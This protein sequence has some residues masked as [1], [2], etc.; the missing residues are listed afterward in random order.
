MNYT[1]HQLHVFL[2]ITQNKS[3][4]KA[5][6]ELHLT[7]P[8]VSI[9][10]KNFQDQFDVP[11]TEVI[12]R[13]LFVTDFGKE[14]AMAAEKILNEVHA[15]NYKTMAFKG[16]LTG[17]LKISV[18]STGKYVIPYFLSDFLKQNQG[19][20]L[21]LDVT[22]KTKVLKNLERNEVDFSLVSVLP[23]TL[24]IEK[25]E[26]MPNSLFLVANSDQKMGKGIQEK[27]IIETLPII[28]REQGSGTRYV[29]EKFIEQ[30]QLT[31]SK[32]MV[33]TGNEAVKQAVLAGLGC[34][35]MPLIGIK[36]ELNNGDLQIIPVKGLPIQSNWNLIW[37]KGKKFSPVAD[38]YLKFIQKEKTRIIEQT[39]NWITL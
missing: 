36:N 3:I 23:E 28:Y 16:Q 22:N 4:T 18:V 9:Q 5:A 6:M 19:V 32:K 34:S 29:M 37:L 26:L 8:A 24:Q 1:L 33:L 7:Q 27:K 20:E 12:G 10:L 30:N 25:V 15:I 31:V 14:I 21:I 17:R 2:K 35:I 13:K 11:L 39:F 38:A